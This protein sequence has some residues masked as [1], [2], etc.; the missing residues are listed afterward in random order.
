MPTVPDVVLP[1]LNE[2]ENLPWVL[3]RLPPGFRAVVVD[4]GSTDG[5]AEVATER[6][7]T[8]VREPKRGFGSACWSG[9]QACEDEI[10]CF[11]DCDGSFDAKEL[12]TVADPIIAGDADLVLQRDVPPGMAPNRPPS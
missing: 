4:N 5:S 11:M 1:V 6:G 2:A 12:P 7:A 9:L 3:E 8:V 10:V